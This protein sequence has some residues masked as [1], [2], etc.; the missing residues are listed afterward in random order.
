MGILRSLRASLAG[1][2]RPPGP[3]D[4]VV[5]GLGNPGPKYA[6]TRHNL[7]FRCIDRIAAE[8]SISLSRRHR[9]ALVGE[10]TVEG[11]PVA[12]AKPRTYVNRSGEAAAYLLARYAL[13]PDRLLVVYDDIALPP[14][15]IRLRP[16]GSAGGHNGAR[17]ITQAIGAQAFPRI[18][19]GV[20]APPEGVDQVEHVLGEMRGEELEAVEEAVERAAQA[21]VAVLTDGIDLGDEPLQL[22]RCRHAQSPPDRGARRRVRRPAPGVRRLRRRRAPSDGR[23]PLSPPETRPLWRRG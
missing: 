17:S 13:P 4:L 20:G 21:T 1:S 10:G 7:G 16:G 22:T 23:L 12:L 15:K 8:Y 18:R 2:R 9:T 3:L 19:I 14:G 6:G 11:R 5:V